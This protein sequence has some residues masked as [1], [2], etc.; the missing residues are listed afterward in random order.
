MKKLFAILLMLLLSVTCLASC[1]ELRY[2]EAYELIEK[3]DYK[4][5]YEIFSDLGD[6]KDAKREASRFHYITTKV[7]ITEEMSGEAD[8]LMSVDLSLNGDNL[9]SGYVITYGNGQ[10]AFSDFTYDEQG[11]LI[12]T[13]SRE[14]DGR[15]STVARAFDEWGRLVKEIITTSDGLKQINEYTY[16]EDGKLIKRVYTAPSGFNTFFSY[17]YDE[18]GNR[19]KEEENAPNGDAV[20][21]YEYDADGRLIRDIRTSKYGNTA[22]EYTYSRRGNL[23]KKKIITSGSESVYDYVYG[24]ND[25][26]TKLVITNPDG[27]RLNLEYSYT[28]VYI[29]FDSSDVTANSFLF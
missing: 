6:Y 21:R 15:E 28:F 27:S 26:V 22:N 20:T 8:L 5:A 19:I 2:N 12:K 13:T 4:A 29:P 14:V 3:G 25:T 18:H 9:A 16:D 1:G 10:T 23:I 11:N 17:S 7:V 24:E